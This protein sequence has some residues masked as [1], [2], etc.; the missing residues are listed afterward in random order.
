[1]MPQVPNASGPLVSG[2]E[3]ALWEIWIQMS[4][5]VYQAAACLTEGRFQEKLF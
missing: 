3:V 1:M 4:G 5:F 2:S